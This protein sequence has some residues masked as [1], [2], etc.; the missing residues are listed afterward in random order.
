VD[1]QPFWG[2]ASVDFTA[3]RA[4]TVELASNG[5]D[6]SAVF[7]ESA[8]RFDPGE[9]PLSLTHV[10][11]LRVKVNLPA[12]QQLA[13]YRQV[14]QFGVGRT[15]GVRALIV[16]DLAGTLRT[17]EFDYQTPPADPSTADEEQE[18]MAFL[19]VFSAQGMELGDPNGLVGAA[20]DY[21]ATVL[22]TLQRRSLQEHGSLQLDGLDVYPCLLPAPVPAAN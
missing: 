18:P 22:I 3:P 13:G 1:E 8:F 15:P 4:V 7:P 11:A 20:P 6:F 10:V 9:G 12:G 2:E 14:L 17:V 16:V 19:R 21:V 5:P